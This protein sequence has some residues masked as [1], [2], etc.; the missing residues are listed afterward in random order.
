M[1]T[2][3]LTEIRR[4]FRAPRFL[5]FVIAFPVLMY[6]LQANVFVKPGSP[7]HAQFAAVIMINMM[8]FGTFAAANTSGGRLALE[9]ALGWQRQLRLT[10]LTGAGYL[11]GKALSGMLVGLPALILVPLLA[12][13]VEGVHLDPAGWVRI[14]AGVWLGTI[15]LVLLG[16]LIGQ[17]GTPDSMQPI[18][19]LVT[20]GMGFLG[21]LWIPLEGMPSWMHDLAQIMPTYWVLQVARP[22]VT[23]DMVVSLPTAAGVLAAWTVVLGALVIRRYRKD[24]ARV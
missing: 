17:F 22:A 11:G 2:Y 20:L 7:E 8:T 23:G 9:R 21:G 3:L 15:P 14:L 12:V 1:T 13:T 6:L 24:S 19:M 16:L 18:S 5:I 4:N 10:P